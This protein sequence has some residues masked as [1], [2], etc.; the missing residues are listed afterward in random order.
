MGILDDLSTAASE[1]TISPPVDPDLEEACPGL[2]EMLVVDRWGDGT[3]RVLPRIIVDRVAG[4]F[5]VTLQ[6][7]SLFI[8]KSVFCAKLAGMGQAL[9]TALRD[10]ERPWLR[11]EKSFRNRHG[12]KVQDGTKKK[13]SGQKRP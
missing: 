10:P 11:I 2:W 9:E 3:E 8:K 1:R 6:D 5:M 7:D 12:P 13:R 4:G